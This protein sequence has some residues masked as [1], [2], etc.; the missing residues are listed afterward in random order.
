MWVS[1]SAT[2]GALHRHS[3]TATKQ[4]CYVH[5]DAAAATVQRHV[6]DRPVGTC[7]TRSTPAS[8][9]YTCCLDDDNA[10]ACGDCSPRATVSTAPAAQDTAASAQPSVSRVALVRV[11]RSPL[12]ARCVDAAHC[13]VG[14]VC[15]EAR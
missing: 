4:E 12:T 8:T 2:R 10:M 3:E 14:C 13:A 7:S 15:D 9:M 11:L 6:G 1:R 5:D